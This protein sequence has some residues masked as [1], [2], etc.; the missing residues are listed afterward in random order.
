MTISILFNSGKAAKLGELQLDAT[1]QEE[2]T[3]NNEVTEFPI[4]DGSSISDH[5][6]QNPDEFSIVGFVTNTP[7]NTLQKNNSEVVKKV[8]GEVEIKNLQRSDSV[9]NVE[10]AFDSLLKISGRKI[11][12]S[13]TEPEIITI[14]SGLRV[15][16]N[17]AMT[18]LSIPRNA[19]TG[20]VIEFTAKF[21]KITKKN[22]ETIEIPHPATAD[23]DKTQSTVD[24]GQQNTKEVSEEK[25][26]ISY[27]KRLVYYVQR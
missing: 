1:I 24:K 16:S 15:F 18:S 21:K 7:I 22:T 5:I 9:N 4:E 11:D 26:D 17:M 12:G 13:N 19:K 14:V 25:K 2:Q 6:R 8:D 27:A 23:K 20:Q 3:Y 10:L